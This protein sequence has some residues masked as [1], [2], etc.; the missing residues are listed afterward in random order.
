G[1]LDRLAHRL[2][3]GEVDHRVDRRLGKNAFERRSV[4]HVGLVERHRCGGWGL[5]QGGEHQALGGGEGVGGRARVSRPPGGG[6]PR[7]GEGGARGGRGW[8]ARSDFP[9]GKKEPPPWRGFGEAR[10][11]RPR[12]ASLGGG[13]ARRSFNAGAVAQRT[14]SPSPRRTFCEL[15]HAHAVIML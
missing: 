13:A 3:A 4:A 7:G 11:W 5:A 1:F 12:Q 15:L 9:Q 8:L 2:E 14:P 10:F 6:A